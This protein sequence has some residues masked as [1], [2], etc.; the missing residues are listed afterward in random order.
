MAKRKANKLLRFL[1]FAII[2]L[3]IGILGFTSWLSAHYK[4]L[5][6]ERLPEIITKAS[7]SAYHISI[8]DIDVNVFTHRITVT[9]IKLWPDEKQ[10][11][12]LR[13]QHRHYPTTLSNVLIPRAEL[14]GVIWKDLAGNKSLDCENA[15]IHQIN[16]SLMRIPY[17][18]D[19][20]PMTN[21][22]R[23]PFISRI[24]A[25]RLDFIRPN[26]TYHYKGP[27]AT[28]DCYMKGGKAM[29]NNWV[30]N[31]DQTKDTST[32]LYARSGKVRF[33]SFIFS[34]PAGRYAIKTP[35]LDFETGANTVTL[36]SAKI[37]HMVDND[38]QT[39]K[40]KEIYNLDFPEIELTGFNWNRL[41][42]D[43][44]LSIP[45][46]NA[47]EPYIDVHY[48]RENNPV[49]RRIGDYPHQ[50]LLQVGLKTNIEQLNINKGHFKYT[51]LTPKGD[52][53]TVEF[54]GIRGRFENVTNMY[55]I[56]EK[57]PGCIVNLEGKYLNKS[58]VT[59]KFDL[60]LTDTMGRFK[61][62]GSLQNLDGNDVTPQARVFTIV[63]VTSFHLT[64][65]DIHVEGD[66]TYSKG[67]F[68]VLYHDLK[69]SLFKFDTKHREGKKGT[70]AFLGSA[71]FLYSDNPLPGKDVRK[72]STS[73]ARDTTKGFIGTIWQHMY[74]AAKKTAVRD[75]KLV[76][77]T[78]GPETNKGEKPKKGFFTE[79]FGRKK[80]N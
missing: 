19:T 71:L 77:L 53:G 49:N 35:D 67:N 44:E 56:I 42:N 13:K 20:L 29:L 37:R 69:I 54:T 7:D 75:Q 24:S 66:E 59:I 33:D 39:G 2:L 23:H 57:R 1:L 4:R 6:T 26:V 72:V 28:F 8:A 22:N 50:L 27:Q 18:E 80:D 55:R 60:A 51:E 65:M 46:V 61:A 30:Y 17:P 5:I 68:I 73:F 36:K 10:I 43:G 63:K 38:Q 47:T 15:V 3:M 25:K 48:I 58:P 40:E 78:D 52:E 16:W 14:Y 62:D 64:N 31:Y 41:I 32:F 70:L 12:I 9:G 11:S 79:L 45:K 34:K 74:R 21:K 76:T